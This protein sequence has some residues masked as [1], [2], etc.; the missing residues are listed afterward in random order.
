MVR[1]MEAAES[2]RS[3][4]R[5]LADRAARLYAPVVHSAALLSFLGWMLAT[6]D[7]HRAI[8][9]AVAV[10]II[11]C[12]CALGLA[13][14]M[15]QVVAARRLFERG[16]LAKDGSALE[17][18]SEIDTILFDKTGTLTL[19]KP[20]LRAAAI[21]P[22]ALGVA[23]ALGACSRHPYARA[24]ATLRPDAPPPAFDTITEQAGL[25][26]E[27][28]AGGDVWRL[29]RAAWALADGGDAT[30]DEESG[31]ILTRNGRFVTAFHFEDDARPDAREAL[32]ALRGSGFALEILSGDRAGPV[33]RLA[34]ALGVA[35]FRSDMLPGEKTAHVSAL[36]ATGRRTLMVGDGLND[37]PAL[38]AAYVSMTP[39]NAADIG[40]Q[41]A[42]F[43]FL[44][45]SL[46][47]VPFTIAVARAA[48]RLVRQNFALA[49]LYN[50]IALPIAI[51][52]FVTPL[53][54]ALA[55]SGSSIIVVANA[56]RLRGRARRGQARA[57][58]TDEAPDG[59]APHRVVAPA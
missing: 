29:G 27:G 1:L 36:A 18:L 35:A 51:A 48:R 25:G 50:L 3:G 33:G 20:A 16:I 28:T 4:Y 15:V 8:T 31:T 34:D 23:A 17:R 55:M 43:V 54:A 19:G 6:G 37:A 46:D 9:I 42:D 49:I 30:P 58:T 57:R 44:R 7:A 12:P 45:P 47:A 14:P 53:V 10:L 56:L 39:A 41:A 13:V 22:D 40:R 59:F 2:G 11:T 26:L 38:A 21:A 5:R 52:G 24:L 32:A